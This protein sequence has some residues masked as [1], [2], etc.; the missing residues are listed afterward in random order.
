M[1]ADNETYK[2]EMSLTKNKFL[3][4]S[5]KFNSINRMRNFVVEKEPFR[6]RRPLINFGFL[7]CFFEKRVFWERKET[8]IY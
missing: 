7:D 3:G 6:E 5:R 1:G 4:K 8:L 2:E